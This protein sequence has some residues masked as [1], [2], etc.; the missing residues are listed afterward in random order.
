MACTWAGRSFASL[1]EP[2]R[3]QDVARQRG[4]VSGCGPG[5]D[6]TLGEGQ[7]LAGDEL[8]H[9]ERGGIGETARIDLPEQRRPLALGRG[10]GGRRA[11]KANAF[12]GDG[13]EAGGDGYRER[14]ATAAD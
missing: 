6:A 4:A 9:R 7:V 12:P 13:I 1:T 10:Q 5:P 8:A 14:M 3:W 11:L 2:D